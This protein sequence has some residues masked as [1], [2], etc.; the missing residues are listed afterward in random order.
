MKK[1]VVFLTGTRADYGKIK[2]LMAKVL[3]SD[4]YE[5]DIFVTG[6]HMLSKYGSTYKEIEKDGFKNLFKFV[7]TKFNQ[8]MDITLSNTI[9]GFSNYVSEMEPDLIVVHGDRVEA[10]A[11]A[12]VGALNNIK[13][14]HI[15]GG[16]VSGTID[17]SIRHA[18]TKFAHI[19]MVANEEARS[20][21]IQL[22]E[23]PDSVFV[24]GS[25][26]ID[27]MFSE[28]LPSLEA[29]FDHYE[30]K[31][32]EFGI[33]MYHPVT[34][35]LAK[36]KQNISQVVDALI[37]SNENYVVVYPNND[38]GS[39]IIL[40]EFNRLDGNPRFK[41]FP[42]IKFEFFLTLLK[43]CKFM[44]GN[45][46]AGVRETSVYGVPSIDL[47]SRQ[48]G[49]YDTML[50]KNIVSVKEDTSLILHYIK[51]IDKV[52]VLQVSPFGEGNSDLRFLEILDSENVWNNEFQKKF[53]G[54]NQMN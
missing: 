45:S 1:K 26:D 9:V 36:L 54:L 15:E 41:I 33:F 13:V 52:P 32:D 19:H 6:M 16:E 20:R 25:P 2:S 14:A 10:L 8:N 18:I 46:S 35:E 48:Q 17:E 27:I 51:N 29:A 12:V 30:I 43:N 42:S 47:G 7:N 31:F 53:I 23:S 34:T 49:R 21:V 37:E 28:S 4:K 5:L 39:S 22:G 40:E 50:S 38:E 3:K 11:G 24:I 44:I